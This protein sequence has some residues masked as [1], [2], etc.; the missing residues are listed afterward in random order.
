MAQVLQH[1][2]FGKCDSADQVAEYILEMEKIREELPYEIDGIV[3]KVNE[4]SV[5]DELGFTAKF[6]KWATA[7]KF[8]ALEATTILEDIFLTV[9]RTG[10]IT[11]NA[12]LTPVSLMGSTISRATLHNAEYIKTKDIRIGDEVVVIK[13]GDVIPRVE[14]S[15]IE[16]R[17]GQME[18]IV[19]NICPA[20]NSDLVTIILSHANTKEK[21]KIF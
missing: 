8:K 2:L 1:S 18:Y 20:C 15:L 13:A 17:N 19:P 7:Y 11:P 10:K 3:I 4:Y 12:Q 6:P 9:G 21:R 16:K 14:R 5:Q